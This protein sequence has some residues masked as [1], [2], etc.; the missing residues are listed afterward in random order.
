MPISDYYY[1]RSLVKGFGK[2]LFLI[3]LQDA[4][5]DGGGRSLLGSVAKEL[6]ETGGSFLVKNVYYPEPFHYTTP[7]LVLTS[8]ERNREDL[9]LQSNEQVVLTSE[10]AAAAQSVSVTRKK[11]LK[12]DIGPFPA[13]PLNLNFSIDYDRMETIAVSL[14]AG[15]RY[16]YIP[17]D[18]LARLYRHLGGDASRISP[19]P[20]VEIDEELIIHRMV[21]ARDFDV[22][23]KSTEDFKG[24]VDAKLAAFNQLPE[25]KGKVTMQRTSQ[26]TIAAKVSGASEYVVAL[27]AIDWDDLR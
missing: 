8:I 10:I 17:T 23:F 16:M 21:L 26:R 15:T 19:N 24:D 27:A 25:A 1:A 11:S 22:S 5:S 3:N 9:G 12:L 18:Y 14:G 13:L 4:N 7:Q 6:V 2:S 20:A